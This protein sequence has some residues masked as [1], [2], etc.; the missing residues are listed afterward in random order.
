MVLPITFRLGAPCGNKANRFFKKGDRQYRQERYAKAL[1]Y[2]DAALMVEPSH[3]LALTY[4]GL[5]HLRLN[6]PEKACATW[7]R[8]LL[9]K[10]AQQLRKD[11]C[12][13]EETATD[14]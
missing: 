2:F 6:Q 13:E 1:G 10:E 4:K 5:A 3:P 11:Y 9:N 7:E 12:P 8:A 14:E